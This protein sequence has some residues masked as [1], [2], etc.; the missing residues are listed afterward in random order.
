MSYYTLNLMLIIWGMIWLK[1]DEGKEY[2]MDYSLLCLFRFTKLWG[3]KYPLSFGTSPLFF[4]SFWLINNYGVGNLEY[5]QTSLKI[6]WV[7]INYLISFTILGVPPIISDEEYLVLLNT[8]S[9]Y[10][11]FGWNKRPYTHVF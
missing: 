5:N 11:Q 2:K 6:Y 1:H 8:K 7:I 4:F 9:T 10:K 3:Q